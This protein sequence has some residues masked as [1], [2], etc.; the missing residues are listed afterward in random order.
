[1]KKFGLGLLCGVLISMSTAVVAA[2]TIQA[3]LFPSK[4]D[5]KVNNISSQL[6]S[7]QDA[8]LNYNNKTYIPLRSFAEA[9]G[10]KVEYVDPSPETGN[11]SLITISS[12]KYE[13]KKFENTIPA[14][15]VCSP[16]S[17]V[18]NV[19]DE[20]YQKS[21][22][23]I[24]QSNNFVFHLIN[25]TTINLNANPTELTFDV[26]KE[27]VDGTQG[28]LVYQYKLPVLSG[29]VPLSSGY[30]LTIPW[31]QIGSDGKEIT[32]GNYIVKVSTPENITYT[33]NGGTEVRDSPAIQDRRCGNISYKV[34]YK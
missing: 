30:E 19:P 25:R 17:L 2:N 18:L 8:V 34:T 32:P 6:D 11:M 7:T 4:I 24:S 13:L 29:A 16:L 21:E 27:T 1:M 20:Y 12:N 15:A 28:A 3:Y 33:I 23:K 10:A 31:N 26:Y 22:L 5:F 14:N 9:M